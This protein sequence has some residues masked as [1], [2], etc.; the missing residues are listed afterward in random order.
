MEKFNGPKTDSYYERIK[1]TLKDLTPDPHNFVGALYLPC[2]VEQDLEQLEIYKNTPEYNKDK[3]NTNSTL[4][5]KTFTDMVEA[6]DWF[7]EEETYGDDPDYLGLATFPTSEIDDT[8]NHIDVIGM[9]SNETTNH[10]I[11]PFAIDLTY[12]ND[13]ENM[14]KKFRRKHLYGKTETAPKWVSEFGESYTREDDF[15]N[16][17]VDSRPLP[18]KYRNGLKIPG[19]TSAKYFEDNNNPE[20][21]IYERGR[22][23]VMPRFIVG[24]APKIAE[25]LYGG[26]PTREYK[27]KYGESAFQKKMSEYTTAKKRAKWCTLFECSEQASDIRSMIE[28]MDSEET[29]YMAPEEL[30]EA[31]K[32]IV[33][34]DGYFDKAIK[35]ATKLAQTNQEEKD[36]M[37]YA[38]RDAVRQNIK[39]YSHD[40][41]IDKSWK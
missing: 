9:I 41:Y 14:S 39:F 2:D 17:V 24:Y 12:N 16:E 4:M 33:A 32:Q 30:T 3:E 13:S 28:N 19:F 25:A 38:N 22:I 8:F 1:N 20:D 37:E 34:M 10:E 7:G 21:P 23:V 36:A 29:K 18:H 11:L 15:G 27:E 6:D 35:L 31:K 40:T 26:R 5:E